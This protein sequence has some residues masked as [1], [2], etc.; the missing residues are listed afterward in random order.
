MTLLDFCL[1]KYIK[2]GFLNIGL[3]K[4]ELEFLSISFLTMIGS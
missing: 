3:K 2:N 1:W 4:I